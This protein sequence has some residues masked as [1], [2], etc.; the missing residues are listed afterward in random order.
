LAAML[1]AT[2]A[3]TAVL[4]YPLWVQFAGPQ[5]VPNGV[6]NP[7]YFSADLA[8][9]PAFSPLSLAGDPANARLAT[10]PAEYDTFFGWPLLLVA[11]SCATW[12]RRSPIVWGIGL[13]SVVMAWLS[14]GPQI[15]INGER[16][17]H[18][19][20]FALL[21]GLPVVEA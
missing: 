5:H 14:L 18:R 8:S 10:G 7:W 21:E 2:A 20:L 15:V 1:V 13:A 3:A 12:L 4:A 17:R 19:G 16:T 9:F 6:F 11:L